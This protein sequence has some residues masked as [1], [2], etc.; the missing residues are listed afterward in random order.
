LAGSRCAGS[1]NR[2]RQTGSTSAAPRQGRAVRSR[3]PTPT[4]VIRFRDEPM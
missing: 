2:R 1:D 3:N 4:E